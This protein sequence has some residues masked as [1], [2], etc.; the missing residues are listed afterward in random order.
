M[1]K[2]KEEWK[3]KLTSNQYNILREKG[4][5]KAFSGKYLDTKDEGIYHCAGCGAQLFSSETKFDSKTGWPSFD[6]ALPDA[7]KLC[8][9]Y[10][11]GFRR[12]EVICTKCDGHLGHVFNDGPTKTRKRYCIN[13]CALNMKKS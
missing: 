7:V 1:I 2:S 8:D 12:T 11:H 13:S 5:E 3:K 9:D 4:T 6:K 10:S